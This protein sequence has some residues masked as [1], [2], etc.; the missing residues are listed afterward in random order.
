MLD[1]NNKE[2]LPGEFIPAAEHG[3]LM[4]QVDQWV[5]ENAL[6]ELAKRHVSGKQTT[7]FIK[8]SAMT[9]KDKQFPSWL[10]KN[11]NAIKLP[12][13]SVVFEI[14]ESIAI[15]H[16]VQVK[17]YI[18]WLKTMRCSCAIDHFGTQPRSMEIIK[19]LPADY[20]KIDRSFMH[21][22]TDKSENKDRIKSIV[23][24]AQSVNKRTIAEFVQDA[25]SL[26]ILWQCG[27]DYIQGYFLQRP[28]SS[29]MYDFAD[30]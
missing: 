6:I 25:N 23:A 22:L 15:R 29:M 3:G 17:K 26:S 10:S 28:E 11:I 2:I 1:E 8:L 7:F 21:N 24:L 4:P 16:T 18:N 13:G 14:S 12:A 9:L 5:V 19:E 30:F 27:V 20:L